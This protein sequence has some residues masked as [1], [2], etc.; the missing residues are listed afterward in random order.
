MS[1]ISSFIPSFFNPLGAALF[2]L[3]IPVVIFYFLKLRRTRV[4]VSSLALWQQVIND[5]RVNAPFQKFKRNIL[6]LLQLL[7]LCLVAFAAMQP[8][9][10][11]NAEQL[12]YLPILVDVSASMGAVDKEGRSRLDIAKAEISEIVEGLLPDQ[13]LTLIAIGA[14]ARRLTEF[15]D[16]KQILRDALAKLEVQ[17]VPSDIADGLRLAQALSRTQEI[18]TV[19]FYSDGNLPTKPNPA[20][21]KPMAEVDFDL[22]FSVDFFQI[23]PPGNNIGITAL[24]A[25]RATPETWDVFIRVEGAKSGSTESEVSL[26]ANGQQ[27]GD[28]E[29]I[30]LGPGE[31]QR[32]V[33]KVDAS[34][35]QELEA[36]LKPSGH[37][38]IEVDNKAWL[39]LPKGREVD[40]Y[41][42]GE[43]TTYRHAL[44]ALDGVDVYPLADGSENVVDY[45][46]L[47]SDKSSDVGQLAGVSLFIG[48]VPDELKDKVNISDGQAEV[49]DWQRDASILQHVQLK[50]VVISEIPQKTE[51]VEDAAIEELG[52]EILAYGN[53]G[54]LLLRHRDGIRVQYF[55][56]FHTDRS[57]LPYRVGFPV[58]VA[59]V[60]TEAMQNASLTEL[61]APST[62]VLPAI[63][64][65]KAQAYR[66]TSPSGIHE[67]RNSDDNGLLK[68]ISAPMAGQYEIRN[69]GDL[70][71]KMGVALLDPT[72]TRLETVD[73]ITFNELSVEAE[74]EKILSDKPLWTWFA[75]FAF[76]VLLVEWWYFQK[77]PL[78]IPD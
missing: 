33:F 49:V 3:I 23:D 68:G 18:E 72:E 55:L 47:I 60:M 42:P 48:F 38:A 1:W 35:M 73:T 77:K 45:D 43:L 41:C 15:T 66:V 26:E 6:L 51:G 64:V 4:E 9:L 74:G 46:L 27:V 8:Y 76:I 31:A 56:L 5:Q 44:D 59:N 11:G 10:R 16:N 34:Q 17:D 75:G 63:E 22:P 13:K 29:T 12:S 65:E 69:G 36:T 24:N 58:L 78:G 20:T 2:A 28:D 54:P 62:G 50:E 71:S 70:V 52:Y 61:R 37:D 14:S 32:L 30:V 57:T 7:I 40:V 53:K 39:S 21:G 19:R 67:M 25:R